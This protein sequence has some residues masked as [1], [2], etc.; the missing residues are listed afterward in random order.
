M[1]KTLYVKNEVMRQLTKSSIIIQIEATLII[2]ITTKSIGHIDGG[3][4]HDLLFKGNTVS[5]E[6]SRHTC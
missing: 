6:I 3:D 5:Q 2:Q 4:Y 1:L